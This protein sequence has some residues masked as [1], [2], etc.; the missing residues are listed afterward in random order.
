MQVNSFTAA[1]P[2]NKQ[3]FKGYQICRVPDDLKQII[4]KNDSFKSLAKEYD[5]LVD[6]TPKKMKW[7]DPFRFRTPKRNEKAA[8]ECLI[9]DKN[10]GSRIIKFNATENGNIYGKLENLVES[11][12]KKVENIDTEERIN[13]LMCRFN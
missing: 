1:T 6:A 4:L 7:L 9:N 3:Q 12:L 10:T 2:T 11:M 13:R 5:V 8:L